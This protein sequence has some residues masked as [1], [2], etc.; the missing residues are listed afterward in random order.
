MLIPPTGQKSRHP[1][2]LP[3]VRGRKAELAHFLVLPG[4]AKVQLNP[5]GTCQRSRAGK[6]NETSG[7]SVATSSDEKRRARRH[8]HFIVEFDGEGNRAR[9]ARRRHCRAVLALGAFAS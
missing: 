5:T 3:V 9:A 6:E 2:R 8:V 7:K 4:A 1:H